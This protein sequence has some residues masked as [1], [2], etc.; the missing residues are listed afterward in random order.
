LLP[1]IFP[2]L[3]IYRNA[4]AAGAAVPH[5]QRGKHTTLPRPS[6]TWQPL[7]G[8]EGKEIKMGKRIEKGG[9]GRAGGRLAP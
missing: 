7:V 8:G 4:F 9:H 1:D 3:R 6:R 5:A 2:Y